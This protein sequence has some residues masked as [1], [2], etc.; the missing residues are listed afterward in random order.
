MCMCGV[1]VCSHCSVCVC[2]CVSECVC[3]CVFACVGA[4]VCVVCV[5]EVARAH[6]KNER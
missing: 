4:R 6:R 3:V 5:T 2:V 1:C